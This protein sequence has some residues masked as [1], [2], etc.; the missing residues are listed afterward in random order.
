MYM[1]LHVIQHAHLS[2][3]SHTLCV[4]VCV[5]QILVNVALR[6]LLNLT[7]DPNLRLEIVKMGLLPKIVALLSKSCMMF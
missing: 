5:P 7:F 1:Y 4:C 3:S 6:L 2:L